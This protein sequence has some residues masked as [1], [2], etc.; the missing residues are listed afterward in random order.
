MDSHGWVDISLIT[1]FKRVR[2]LTNDEL[3]VRRILDTSA[4]LEV[5]EDKVRMRREQDVRPDAQTHVVDS[6][7]ELLGAS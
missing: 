4:I 5:S 2:Q 1:S 3:L 6:I 7:N